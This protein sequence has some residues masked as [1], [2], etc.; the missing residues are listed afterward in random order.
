MLGPAPTRLVLL[1]ALPLLS[2]RLSAQRSA[3]PA[4]PPTAAR[5]TRVDTVAGVEWPDAYAWL[6]DDQ[7]RNPEVLAYLRAENAYTE[8]VTRHSRALEK[9]L[10]QDM[11]GRIKETDLSVPELNDGY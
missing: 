3:A 2:A 7:R 9:R 10:F 1:L 4:A 11:V 6:R 8:A 5:I